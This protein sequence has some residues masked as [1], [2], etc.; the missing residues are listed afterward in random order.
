MSTFTQLINDVADQRNHKLSDVLMR[1]KV[2]A[3]QLRG[4]KFRDWI[5]N[6]INGYPN[7]SDL[8]PYRILNANLFGDFGGSFGSSMTH[9][10]LSTNHFPEDIQR[11]LRTEPFGSSVS[12]AEDLLAAEN[13]QIGVNLSMDEVEFFRRFGQRVTGMILNRIVKEVPRS[14]LNE[15]LQN[16]RSRLL[17]FLFELRDKHPEL[18]LNVSNAS[19]IN[20]SEVDRAF[21]QKIFNNI[22]IGGE[23]MGDVYNTGQAGAVGPGA[24][25]E[26]INF[27]QIIRGAI[28]DASLRD[29]A[30][31]LEQLR[32]AMLAAS[33]TE[34]QDKSV[35]AVAEAEEA[36]KKGDAKGV[37]TWLKAAGSWAAMM[38]EKI[39]V[40]IAAKVIAEAVKFSG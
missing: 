40:A 6:E 28:G 19:N 37:V 16:I 10:S 5:N 26:N 14:G 24:K 15:L 29:L 34:D 1:A 17:D 30:T 18:D 38:A 12:Y 9:V 20:A 21:E 32:E 3:H 23:S 27:F 31:E 7:K 35:A 33:K 4:R 25:A 2:L 36:A 13:R 39:S 22:V 8:P 11:S